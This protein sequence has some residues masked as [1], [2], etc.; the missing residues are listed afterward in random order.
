[1]RL[2]HQL[3]PTRPRTRIAF[4]ADANVWT[5]VPP[6]LGP[7]RGQRIRWHVGLW[8]NL[9]AHRKMLL[10]CR[11]GTVGLLA[12]PYAI[13]FEV[14]GP[15][16]QVLGYGILLALVLLGLA[17]WWYVAAFIVI[18]I[19]V[20]QLQ[21]AGAIL[22]EEVGFRRYRNRDLMLLAGWSL[23]ELFWYRPLTAFWRTWATVLVFAGRRPG[24]GTIPR[25]VAFREA[26]E[27]E[28]ELVPAPLP[29]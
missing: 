16:L 5:E 1:M 25:G 4:A 18:S 17:S 26:P 21:T 27:P 29:R 14:V 6:G 13:L 24:W 11:F 7:L 15:V 8:D 3:H 20:G 2:H 22:I 10:R 28:E 19:L 23:A 12:L 9:R